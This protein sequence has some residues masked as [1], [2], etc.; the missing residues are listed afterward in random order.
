ML[1]STVLVFALPAISICSAQLPPECPAPT[2]QHMQEV[3]AQWSAREP[4]VFDDARTVGFRSDA[5][6]IAEHLHRVRQQLALRTPVGLSPNA[7]AQRRGLLETLDSYADRGIFPV[8]DCVPGRSPVF[9]DPLGNACAVGHL[10]ITSGHGALAER[11][12]AEMNLAY[13]HDIAL[14]EVAVWAATHGFTIDELAW[15]QPTYHHMK[16]RDPRLVAS[17]ALANGDRF[18]VFGPA[19]PKDAQKL[20]L[21]RKNTKGE[22]ELATLPKLSGVQV[23]EFSGHLYIGGMPPDKGPSAELY[24]WNG[25]SLQVHDPFTGR[26]AIGSMSVQNGRLTVV[27]YVP[28]KGQPQERVLTEAGAWE[29]IP[30]T[31]VPDLDVPQDRLP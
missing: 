13:V 6:R 8:N 4:S 2:G 15:I 29:E 28:G 9:I 12:S 23:M 7:L 1:R 24:E 11:I 20:R 25:T 10:M 3:N 14:P 31:P 17:I 16:D 26:L 27:G 5:A 22:K 19:S 21:V 18:D 30:P